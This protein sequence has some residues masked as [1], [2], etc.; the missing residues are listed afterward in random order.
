M[1]ALVGER[2]QTRITSHDVL[3]VPDDVVD[4]F[5]IE[6]VPAELGYFTLQEIHLISNI[7][8]VDGAYSIQTVEGAA[9]DQALYLGL[10]GRYLIEQ[11][12]LILPGYPTFQ[13][14]GD[15]IVESADVRK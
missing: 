5:G 14:I 15:G 4:E 3:H 11:Q 1:V 7:L 8:R 13:F 10:D 12:A 6:G 2:G 9:V